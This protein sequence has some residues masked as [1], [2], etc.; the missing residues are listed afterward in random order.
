MTHIAMLRMTESTVEAAAL[1]WLQAVG[2]EIAYGPEIA[3]EEQLAERDS[4]AEVVLLRRL[5]EAVVGLNPGASHEAREA[6]VDRIL[7]LEGAAT[8]DRNRRFHQY[9]AR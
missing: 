7:R 5:R 4:F 9:L 1:E 3:P 6:A 2:Y 8:I